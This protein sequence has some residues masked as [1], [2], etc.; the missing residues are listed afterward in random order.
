MGLCQTN[1]GEISHDVQSCKYQRF[2]HI[3][4][5]DVKTLW[6][7]KEKNRELKGAPCCAP[8]VLS[9]TLSPQ[10]SEDGWRDACA[11]RKRWGAV[12]CTD[13]GMEPLFT[14][15]N[16]FVMSTW[17]TFQRPPYGL[18]SNTAWSE[19]AT[20]SHMPLPA[21][22][23]WVGSMS[24]MTCFVGPRDIATRSTSRRSVS[25]TATGLA[26]PFFFLSGNRRAE[27]RKRVKG[28]GRSPLR[29][30]QTNRSKANKRRRPPSSSP[31]LSISAR[32]DGL[33]PV[34]PAAEAGG[35][36]VAVRRMR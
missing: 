8:F 6:M 1:G 26:L 20:C 30:E 4:G 32:W 12:D 24:F 15:L 29:A 33:K 11:Q 35:N 2:K 17:R 3:V 10:K 14:V 36:E 27:Q 25:P 13:V 7:A 23:V 28:S 5:Q 19:R 16:A 34:G 22:P 18:L 21:K 31:S 9:R